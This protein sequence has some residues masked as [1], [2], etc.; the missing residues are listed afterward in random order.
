MSQPN[1]TFGLSQTTLFR[2]VRCHDVRPAG[3]DKEQAMASTITSRFHKI[4]AVK[5][6]ILPAVFALF[7][8]L[9]CSGSDSV[10]APNPDSGVT[11]KKDGKVT[12]QK[13]GKVAPKQDGKVAPRQEQK[14]QP[15]PD[16]G[17]PASSYKVA[18]VQYG[19]KAYGQVKASCASDAT[20]NICALKEMVRVA[21][22]K[23][24]MLVVL[25]EY[26][27]GKDQKYYEPIP[28]IGSNPGTNT[29][30]PND[31]VIK[32]FSRHAAAQ[33][34]YLVLDVITYKKSTPNNLY[35][36]TQVAFDPSGKVVATHHKFNLFGNE[37]NDLTAGSDVS[38]FSTPLGKVGLLICADIYGSTTLRNKLVNTL[39]ARVVAV[40]SYWTVSNSVSWFQRYASGS[41]VYTVVSNTTHSPGYGGGIYKPDGTALIEKSQA[42][43]SV[44]VASIP[45]K[46]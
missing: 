22:Q 46:P 13:D 11:P 45:V 36:N 3:T 5:R 30:W 35:Y 41:S 10:D 6:A 28:S 33:K 38:V 9:G 37:K 17:P 42:A 24:A 31:L 39:G 4:N 15:Q 18:A 34:V 26:A 8:V 29:A 19:D 43:P 12:Q 21:K 20:P 25:P 1:E 32:V 14:V 23:G 16:K 27:L 2:M 44:L 40:S 7:F